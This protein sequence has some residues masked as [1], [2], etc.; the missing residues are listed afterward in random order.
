MERILPHA[1]PASNG[2]GLAIVLA[3]TTPLVLLDGAFVVRAASGTFCRLFGLDPR[4]VVG[5]ALFALGKGEWNLPN[6][7]SLLNATL[8]GSASIEAYE[9][10]LVR[11]ATVHH[12]VLNAQRLVYGDGGDTSLLLAVTDVT[13]ARLAARQ[14]DDLVREKQMLLEELQHRVANSL[15]IIA[16]VLMLSARKVQSEEARTHLNDAHQRVM[17]IATL[18]KQLTTVSA[19][20]VPLHSYLADL[21]GSIGASM[22]AQPDRLRITTAI[23][24]TITSADR[25]VSMGLIVTELVM[26]ALK[27]AFPESLSTGEIA[28]R[29]ASAGPAW[30]LTVSDNG[31]GKSANA[32]AGL[33]TGIVEALASQ[34]KARVEV[35]DG[36]PGTIVSIIHDGG[37]Q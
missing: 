36:H 21:C 3:S 2:L 7:R 34:L 32:E 14:K 12:L 27:H 22:I 13:A 1:L 4:A 9:L 20:D 30:T 5:N 15:Q 33:G 28:V 11:D 16:S 26:N 35:R 37:A 19:D 18:Q 31:V 8:S 25:S 29:F 24:Q 10:D 6:L 23:D 17:S